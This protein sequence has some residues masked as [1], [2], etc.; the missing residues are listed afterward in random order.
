MSH[1]NSWKYYKYL[2][3]VVSFKLNSWLQNYLSKQRNER[4][5]N[6]LTDNLINLKKKH[7]LW[8]YIN[9]FFIFFFGLFVCFSRNGMFTRSRYFLIYR[10]KKC[11]I[12]IFQ[13]TI[14]GYNYNINAIEMV[15]MFSNIN[16]RSYK[17]LYHLHE[18]VY[19]FHNWTIITNLKKNFKL[20]SWI[21]ILHKRLFF[22]STALNVQIWT[23]RNRDG[24]RKKSLLLSFSR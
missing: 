5:N 4:L 20:F 16:I 2:K 1:Y 3:V 11:H 8:K 15:F 12:S 18:T 24:D 10:I 6:T 22:K 9:F 14:N 7:R 13:Y 23:S 21:F 19:P 17:F